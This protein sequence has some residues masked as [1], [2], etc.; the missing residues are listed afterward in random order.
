M[1]KATLLSDLKSGSPKYYVDCYHYDPFGKD[2]RPKVDRLNIAKDDATAFAN[3]GAG[4]PNNDYTKYLGY[5]RAD[6]N[7]WFLRAPDNSAP[8]GT[9]FIRVWMGRGIG[10]PP[11]RGSDLSMF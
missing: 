5:V 3:N 10:L 4:M 9:V 6:E 2:P 8:G 7:L 1:N 11:T